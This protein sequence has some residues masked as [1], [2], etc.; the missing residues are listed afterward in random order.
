MPRLS[1]RTVQT[2]RK[3]DGGVVTK[4][5]AEPVNYRDD[6]GRWSPID[7]T[8][9]PVA[10]STYD[11]QTVGNS[12]VLQLPEDPSS[13]PVRVVEGSRWLSMR[14]H[15]AEAVR[16]SVHE[17]RAV[18]SFSKADHVFEALRNGMKESL[19]LHSAPSRRT[20]FTYTLDA[21]A[22][23][24]P[25][26]RHDGTIEFADGLGRARFVI[27]PSFMFDSSSTPVVSHQIRTRIRPLRGRWI[28]TMQPRLS[29]LT[30]PERTYPVTIDP[31]VVNKVASSDC[32]LNEGSPTT[33]YCGA[34]NNYIRVG[35]INSSR[36]RGLLKFDVSSI[37]SN[38]LIRGATAWLYLDSS[39]S[40]SNLVA[41]Y[42]L[43]VPSVTWNAASATWNSSGSSGAWN[44]GSPGGTTYSVRSINGTTSGYKSFGGLDAL[45]QGWVSGTIVNKGLVLKQEQESV[46]NTLWFYS[47]NNVDSRPYLAID[48]E[49]APATPTALTV[50]P[51][52]AGYAL[53]ATPQLSAIASDPD[54]PTVSLTFS[55]I[56][57]S[58]VLWTGS[59]G[60]VASGTRGSVTV[61]PGLLVPGKDY[62]VRVTASDGVRT[63]AALSQSLR[64][65]SAAAQPVSTPCS[66][67]CTSFAQPITLWSGV[68]PAAGSA[69]VSISSLPVADALS[70]GS[71][72]T[73]LTVPSPPSQGGITV[74]DP[75]YPKPLAPTIAFPAAANV[76]ATTEIWPS[77]DGALQ[78]LN[79]STSPVSVQLTAIAWTPWEDADELQLADLEENGVSDL[80]PEQ[81]TQNF[82][83]QEVPSG[84]LG[85]APEDCAAA[86]NPALTDGSCDVLLAADDGAITTG[87]AP[88]SSWT[89][90]T[91]PSTRD[92]PTLGAV[93]ANLCPYGVF[94]VYQRVAAC[95]SIKVIKKN[96]YAGRLVG[97]QK[98]R[99]RL[100]IVT[101]R[102]KAPDGTLQSTAFADLTLTSY[103][104]EWYGPLW[105]DVDPMC[106]RG[107]CSGVSEKHLAVTKASPFDNTGNIFLTMDTTS[108][109]NTTWYANMAWDLDTTTVTNQHVPF[110]NIRCDNL[111]Y[112]SSAGCVYPI[113]IDTMLAYSSRYPGIAAH[114]T[115]AQN[116]SFPGSRASGEPLNRVRGS[117]QRKNR[118]AAVRQ[119]RHQG[120]QGSCDEYPFASTEE[121]C[122]TYPCSTAG[123]PRAENNLQGAD[124]STFYRVSR[125]V[126]GD[127][128]WVKVV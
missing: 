52:G 29:W 53:N 33:S 127:P 83:Q 80:T 89:V 79:S 94:N 72:R 84:G 81:L 31:S 7:T 86:Q 44:G 48:Y 12:I 109:T 119:C 23:L 92:V 97:T 70:I 106:D 35:R 63:S 51:G 108:Q 20:T 56:D 88:A 6:S 113:Y 59:T 14:L 55:V 34:S 93:A 115:R 121:G 96:Y 61:S 15:G 43:H 16:P 85:L 111:T 118:R 3:P 128:F 122:A 22:G 36:L 5:F 90:L 71:L 126:V 60:Q 32:W 98:G 41:D 91:E 21:S 39:H 78:L 95:V 102:K 112:I 65:D 1:N 9:V 2:F 105:A 47:S 75:T 30:D 37:P 27:P 19:V 11:V 24:S 87:D 107:M 50:S 45:V 73:V 114:I 42:G 69:E 58:E 103:W 124:I 68:L 18:Y 13:T 99:L 116:H 123:V 74:M 8:L 104:G 125:I 82:A 64:A 67:P 17:N 62:E 28:L 40:Q 54:S 76:T 117:L 66:S 100:F 26:R 10:G 57:G 110:A 4:S 101:Q 49:L 120:A 25:V 77:S 38:A 46:A